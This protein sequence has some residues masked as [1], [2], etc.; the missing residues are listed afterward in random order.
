[1]FFFL[2]W[3]RRWKCS[4]TNVYCLKSCFAEMC[5]C[6]SHSWKINGIKHEIE[7]K[8]DETKKKKTKLNVIILRQLLL[9]CIL[10]INRKF[11]NLSDSHAKRHT[12]H[13][14]QHPQSHRSTSSIS[15]LSNLLPGKHSSNWW[16]IVF[17]VI[18]FFFCAFWRLTGKYCGR[19]NSMDNFVCFFFAAGLS[20]YFH[21]HEW[22]A[23]TFF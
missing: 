21:T 19:S 6:S 9:K 11:K 7:Q 4:E 23:M 22:T 16:R 12:Y 3:N 20:G 10:R 18:F 5:A 8:L 14:H 1:M 2:C 15:C 13:I 17:L